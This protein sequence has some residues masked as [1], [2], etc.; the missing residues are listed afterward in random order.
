[1]KTNNTNNLPENHRIYA[2]KYFTRTR[3]ILEAEGLNPI[4]SMN[5]F[6][7]GNGKL[8]GIDEAIEVV[9]KYS[10]T[11]KVGGELW[12][13]K[14]EVYTNKQ[15]LMII[16]APAQN[17]VELET[18]YLGV[19][20]AAISKV[21]NKPTPTADFIKEKFEKLK[22][23]YEGKS[24]IYFGARHYHWSLDEMIGKAALDGGAVATS[25]DIGSLSRGQ[26]GTGT[27]PHFL[28]LCMAYKYGRDVGTLK[29]AE[30]F[31]KYIDPKIKRITLVD[32]FN[33][34]L[35]DSL[36]VAKYFG[37]RYNMQRI[38]TC[39]ENI[40]EFGSLYNQEKTKDPSFEVG[41]GVTLE[42]ARN[43]RSNL[44][45][46]GYGQYTDTVLS[47]NFGD[48][49]KAEAFMKA[50]AQF[51]KET[52]YSLFTT[53]GIG[54]VTE[55]TFCTGDIF[56]INGKPFSKTGREITNVNYSLLEKVI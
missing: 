9:E 25:T 30:A 13:A 22:D 19:L 7:R 26:E 51:K 52:G 21:N 18:M 56:E 39:G 23:I 55:A 35:T 16:K 33:K 40:G 14:S 12:V 46:N 36:M 38:D 15:P 27:M 37:Q 50:D 1:M 29:A 3:Q 53:V 2:D 11:R 42:L 44:I 47:S 24:M 28:I 10:D 49:K 4:V 41:T 48:E 34:E 8:E 20:S 31:D 43:L 6:A 54:E 32:T 5:V 45:N 17:I